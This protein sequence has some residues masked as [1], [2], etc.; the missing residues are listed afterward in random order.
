MLGSDPGH[1]FA[2]ASAAALLAGRSSTRP[3]WKQLEKLRDSCLLRTDDDGGV[4]LVSVKFNDGL[5]V[6][7]ARVLKDAAVRG[8]VE[9]RPHPRI[10]KKR[11]M[12]ELKFVLPGVHRADIGTRRIVHAGAVGKQST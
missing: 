4:R 6:P 1:G 5:A 8:E 10:E 9:H 11:V 2:H 12:R 3:S 7:T